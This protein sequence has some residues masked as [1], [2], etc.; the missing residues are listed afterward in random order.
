MKYAVL[1]IA[2]LFAGRP[3]TSMAQNLTFEH[4]GRTIEVAKE[5]LPSKMDYPEAMEACKELGNG[6]RLPNLE[7]LKA[8]YEQ[9]YKKG[10]GNF[11]NFW[12]WSSTPNGEWPTSCGW[13][14]NFTSGLDGNSI[15]SGYK[16]TIYRVRAVRTL[17]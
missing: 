3:I 2:L 8:M 17:P 11:D 13:Y 6:W 15:N 12:Y 5:D 9:L 10:K 1:F 4:A 14:L 16:S 7:E